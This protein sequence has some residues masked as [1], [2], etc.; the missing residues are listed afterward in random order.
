MNERQRDLFLWLWSRRRLPGQ[1]A[2]GLRGAAIGAL[3]GVVFAFILLGESGAA[4]G[5]YTGLSAIIPV[6]ERGGLMLA[7]AVPAFAVLGFLLANRVFASQEAMYQS[8]LAAG[9]RV[10]ERKPDMQ[11]GDRGPAIAVGVAAALIAGFIIVLFALY[12]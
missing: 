3:G 9:A 2:I 11:P 8:L 10:P 4:H 5:A 12:W 7:L 1:T 6:I